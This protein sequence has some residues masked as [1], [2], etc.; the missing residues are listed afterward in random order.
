MA[1]LVGILGDTGSGKSRSIKNLDPKSTVIINCASDKDLPFK[2]SNAIWNK[3]N[4]NM[5]FIDNYPDL[6]NFLKVTDAKA[7]HVKVI[8]IDDFRFQMSREFFSRAREQGYGKFTDI[9]RNFQLILELINTMRKDLTIFIMLHDDNIESDKVIV[10]KKIKL[11]GKL[12]E[13]QY[14]PLELMTI[15][16]Y[17]HCNVSK[18]GTAD[19]KFY[20][21][22]TL[23][24][25][26]E[27]PAKSPEEMF[28]SLTISNDL[29][30][31]VKKIEEYYG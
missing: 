3:E 30:L 24:N 9:A 12:V 21:N 29:S 8:V 10:G 15:C 4:K 19:W 16:L 25:G 18:D 31:I 1:R 7:L 11:V 27:I 28:E 26:V 5:F 22:R 6:T 13:D 2:G 23:V 14:N 20:T 17:A